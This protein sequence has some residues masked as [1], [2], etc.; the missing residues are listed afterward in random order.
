MIRDRI[1]VGCKSNQVREKL[2]EDASLTLRKAIDIC[3]AHEA[4]QNKLQAM[5]KEAAIDIDRL[6]LS[7]STTKPS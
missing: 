4:S 6:S 3:R 5:S 1:L 2:L 7:K